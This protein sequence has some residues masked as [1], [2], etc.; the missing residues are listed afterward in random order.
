[1]RVQAK[2]GGNLGSAPPPN[3]PRAPNVELQ[4][5][6]P[7][8]GAPTRRNLAAAVCHIAEERLAMKVHRTTDDASSRHTVSV[9]TVDGLLQADREAGGCHQPHCPASLGHTAQAVL[10]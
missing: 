2:E 1:M 8:T 4:Q 5:R 9:A 6:E 10:L 7:A 3:L